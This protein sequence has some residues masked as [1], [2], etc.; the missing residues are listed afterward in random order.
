MCTG[1]FDLPTS[2]WR[3]AAL[4]TGNIK[5]N[6]GK[7]HSKISECKLILWLTVRERKRP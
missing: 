7:G 5:V 4:G 3:T 1:D 2:R 6:T